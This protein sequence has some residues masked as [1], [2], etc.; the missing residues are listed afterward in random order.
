[1][2][3]ESGKTSHAHPHVTLAFKFLSFTGKTSHGY[4]SIHAIHERRKRAYDKD[5][6]QGMRELIGV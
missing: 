6:Q 5:L 2:V 4:I 3:T 1:M